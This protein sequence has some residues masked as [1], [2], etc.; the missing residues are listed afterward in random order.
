M[1]KDAQT[2]LASQFEEFRATYIAFAQKAESLLR[3]LLSANS[4][5][6]HSIACRAK[7]ANSLRKKIE[8]KENKYK[9]LA[10]I[11]DLV[12]VRVI[13]MFAADVDHIASVIASE[14]EVDP[15]NTID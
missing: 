1:A 6:V 12:G 11:T 8:R 13:T 9:S 15:D 4:I 14:F 3:E 2:D 7:D 5:A 10:D